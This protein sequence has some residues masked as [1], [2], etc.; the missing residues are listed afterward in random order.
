VPNVARDVLNFKEEYDHP[1]GW[2]GWFETSY[3]NSYFLNNANTVGAPAYW[4]M[5]VNIHKNVE[6]K[7]NPYVRFAKFYFEVD[8][9]ADKTFVASGN[10]IADSTAD[11][12]K[13]LFFAGYGRAFYGGIT[14]GLF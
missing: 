3:W 5:N 13:T 14:L 11:A 10:V 4:L 12:Q 8:N 7:N 6:F 9:L 2:G 1:S